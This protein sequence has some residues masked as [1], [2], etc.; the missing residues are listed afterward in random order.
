[1]VVTTKNVAGDTKDNCV[2]IDS[3]DELPAFSKR[4]TVDALTLPGDWEP[5]D[6]N[7]VSG[8]PGLRRRPGL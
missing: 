1:M 8:R 6:I 4:Q 5:M 7:G 3:D 2:D